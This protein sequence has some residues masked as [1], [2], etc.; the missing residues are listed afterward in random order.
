MGASSCPAAG[1]PRPG[2][3]K[4]LGMPPRNMSSQEFLA[5]AKSVAELMPDAELVKNQTGNLAILAP[6]GDYLGWVDL[7]TGIVTVF[8]GDVGMG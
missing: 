2:W 7:R 5:A 6:D 8:P 1:E 3:G 4:M